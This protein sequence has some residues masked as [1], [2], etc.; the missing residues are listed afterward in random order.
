MFNEYYLIKR[1]AEE[2]NGGLKLASVQDSFTYKG[3]IV[4]TPYSNDDVTGTEFY[5]QKAPR[6]GDKVVF[7]KGCGE[8]VEFN[9]ES[10]KVVKLEDL[11]MPL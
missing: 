4:K 10:M 5:G 7:L 2:D 6:I 8:D 9:G 11:I 3:E 1:I